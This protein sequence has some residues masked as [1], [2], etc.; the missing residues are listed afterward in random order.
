MQENVWLEEKKQNC[1]KFSS[2]EINTDIAEVAQGAAQGS[3]ATNSSWTPITS[4]FPM[5]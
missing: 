2:I 3:G 1:I 4:Y 5:R